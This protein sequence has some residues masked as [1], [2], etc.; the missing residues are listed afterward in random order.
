MYS[1]ENTYNNSKEDKIFKNKQQEIYKT[2][3]KR[4]L[5]TPERHTLK[6][7]H[8]ERPPLVLGQDDSTT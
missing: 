6:L 2:Y 8:M 7:K 4:S 3:T 5:N 1:R